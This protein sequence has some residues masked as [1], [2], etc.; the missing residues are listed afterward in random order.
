MPRRD[1]R[2]AGAPKSP[3]SDIDHRRVGNL[4]TFF[5]RNAEVLTITD[6][7]DTTLGVFASEVR[8]VEG[9]TLSFTVETTAPVDGS[10]LTFTA[11]TRV[12]TAKASDFTAVPLLGDW[13]GQCAEAWLEEAGRVLSLRYSNR[14]GAIVGET[15]TVGGTVASVDRITRTVELNLWVKNARDEIITPGSARVNL[16]G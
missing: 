8:A 1:T 16:S 4:Q 15:F 2:S 11:S 3:N 5:E 13:L 14:L 9:G 12:A 7:G 6:N 10:D